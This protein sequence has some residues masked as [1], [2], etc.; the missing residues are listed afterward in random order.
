MNIC[1]K[2][3]F[4][5]LRQYTICTY[6]LT[7]PSP[8][9]I[10]KSKPQIQKEKGE[11]GLWGSPTCSRRILSKEG[12]KCLSDLSG[13]VGPKTINQR[14]NS[15]ACPCQLW[16]WFNLWIQ[17]SQLGISTWDTFPTLEKVLGPSIWTI[18]SNSYPLKV[19]V[20]G[21]GSKMDILFLDLTLWDLALGLDLGLWTH[22]C[23]L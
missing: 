14:P 9:P 18:Y 20:G 7:S 19:W 11:F 1:C 8:S 6:I 2:V 5:I 21:E 16:V 3:L 23:Q 10:P 13:P 17:E 12:F 22:A 4:W 15:W